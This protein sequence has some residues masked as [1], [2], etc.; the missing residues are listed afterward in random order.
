[1]LSSKNGMHLTPL[2]T[3]ISFATGSM[4]HRA[5]QLW[6]TD[7]ATALSFHALTAANEAINLFKT[8]YIKVVGASPSESELSTLYEAT[9]FVTGMCDNYSVKYGTP[10]PPEYRFLS[11]EQKISVVVEDTRQECDIC[12]ASGRML[13]PGPDGRYHSETKPCDVCGG[14]GYIAHTLEGKLDGLVQ[15]IATGRVDVLE[16]KSYNYRPKENSLRYNDQFM[17]YR[18]LVSKLNL[19]PTGHRPHVLYDGMWRRNSPPRG[20]VFDDLFLR[21]DLECN[22]NELDEF[23]RYLPRQLNEMAAL[24]SH[25]DPAP[26]AHARPHRPWMGCGDCAAFEKLCISI[27]RREDYA[28]LIRSNY[29]TRTDDVELEAEAVE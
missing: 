16:R 18:W 9:E 27:T 25:A 28:S 22:Q 8:N 29:T 23:E 26:L 3:P 1:M 10:L 14:V 12:N 5:H 4:L 19:G 24:Y 17:A 15:H 7:P 13:V 2:Q 6:I 21:L 20:R 11:A